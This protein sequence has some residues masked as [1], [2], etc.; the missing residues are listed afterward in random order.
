MTETEKKGRFSGD[1]EVEEILAGLVPR[2]EPP[3]MRGRILASAAASGKD[4]AM[5]PRM[6]FGAVF[7]LALIAVVLAGDALLSRS[8][9]DAMSAFFC[10]TSVSPPP[11]EGLA[12]LLSELSV[13]DADVENRTGGRSFITRSLLARM[14][15]DSESGV[16]IPRFV[17]KLEGWNE[18]EAAQNTP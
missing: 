14:G 8:Q 7:C 11:P 1:G 12:R 17:T 2:S 18:D 4:I 9:L 5:T 6:W 15:P 13:G 3:G 16:S 10:R